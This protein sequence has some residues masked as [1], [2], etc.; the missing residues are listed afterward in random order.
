MKFNMQLQSGGIMKF[1]ITLFW[2]IDI[3]IRVLYLGDFIRYTVNVG[4]RFYVL[5]SFK[6]A[7]ML[8]MTK[9]CSLIPVWMA[10]VWAG[11]A[12]WVVCWVCCPV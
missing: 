7:V 12:Q 2:T 8:D 6:H 11:I 1:M 10:L 4:L 3:Q 5:I 9:L